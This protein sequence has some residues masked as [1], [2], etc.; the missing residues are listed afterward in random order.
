MFINLLNIYNFNYKAG[1]DTELMTY[2]FIFPMKTNDDNDSFLQF[3]LAEFISEIQ[4][5]F[6]IEQ[7]LNYLA[8]EIQMLTPNSFQ[9]IHEI[10]VDW[11]WAE[12]NAIVK[13]F[14]KMTIK[15]YLQLTFLI[16]TTGEK[17][18]LKN[19]VVLLECSSHLTK[20]MKNDVKNFF[21]DNKNRKTVYEIMGK[22]F[23]CETW[24][25]LMLIMTHFIN[26]FLSNLYNKGLEESLIAMETFKSLQ[27][28]PDP[29]S[30]TD[31]EEQEN[32]LPFERRDHKEIYK[33]SP[34]YQVR[35][36]FNIRK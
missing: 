10:V 9:L 1:S 23:D 18:K 24:D 22:L 27:T 12:M 36:K 32:E 30:A 34:F 14:N 4:T 15:E 29:E 31:N 28:I 26:I 13:A 3:N 6:S 19:L 33:D 35:K 2:V 7:F 8:N 11:S 20:T 5:S 16:M 21:P 17:L 25:D